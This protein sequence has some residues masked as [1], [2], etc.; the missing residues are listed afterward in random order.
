[1]KLNEPAYRWVLHR[2][3]SKGG[4]LLVLLWIAA[5]SFPG[6]EYH[7]SYTTISR[8]TRLTKPTVVKAVFTLVAMGELEMRRNTDKS[9]GYASNSYRLP[10]LSEAM[11]SAEESQHLADLQV[12]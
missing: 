1:M 7:A 2:S 5:N 12:A 6:K 9:G 3:E 4:A 10:W 8:W 11:E